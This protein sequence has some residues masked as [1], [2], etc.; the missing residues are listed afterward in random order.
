MSDHLSLRERLAK[1]MGREA[2][3]MAESKPSA[4]SVFAGVR[5]LVAD[6]GLELEP[7]G[8]GGKGGKGGPQPVIQTLIE[9]HGGRVLKQPSARVQ[10]LVQ[11]WEAWDGDGCVDDDR[12]ERAC[13]CGILVVPPL[14]I[15]RCVERGVLVPF[16][17]FA[18]GL[19]EG[20]AVGGRVDDAGGSLPASHLLRR[21]MEGGHGGY[22]GQGGG[23][24][25]LRERL[26]GPIEDSCRV[27]EEVNQTWHEYL[28][29]EW[30]RP[31]NGTGNGTDTDA[32]SAEKAGVKGKRKG[33]GKG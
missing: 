28:A 1:R 11:A 24:G 30:P 21:L 10:F 15:E 2:V 32:D 26:F 17:L 7:S 31:N 8:V 29:S 9:A 4:S 18:M 13:A 33:K 3:P 6:V 14:Y 5:F 25:G 19:D 20:G 12:L 22:G 27:N 16:P 23:Q